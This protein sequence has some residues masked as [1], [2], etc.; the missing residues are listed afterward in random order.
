MSEETTNPATEGDAG[1]I[2]I[3]TKVKEIVGLMAGPESTNPFTVTAYKDGFLSFDYD[4]LGV[5]SK[6]LADLELRLDE[7][8]AA[9][10]MNKINGI[11]STIGNMIPAVGS[12]LGM[13]A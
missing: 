12:V 9:Q 7:A 1:K 4:A 3:A 5:S 11:I 13:F 2:A 8:I 10:D 6:Q